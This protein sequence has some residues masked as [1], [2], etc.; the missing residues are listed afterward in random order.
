M[1]KRVLTGLISAALALTLLAGCGSS[2]SGSSSASAPK[3]EAAAEETAAGETAEETAEEPAAEEGTYDIAYV[4]STRDEF[5]G[6]LEE[7]VQE[8][9]DAN[10]VRVEMLYAGNDSL[11]MIDCVEAA[12]NSDKDA[13]IINLNAAEDAQACIEAAGDMKVVFI[14]RVPADYAVLG[15][16]AAAVASDEHQSGKFQGEFLAEYF[17]GTGKTD[18]TYLLLRGTGGLV[19]TELRTEGAINALKEGGIN[20]TEAAVV[21]ADYNREAAKNAMAE[22]LSE[23][24]FDCIISNN[25]AM[26]LGAIAAMEEADM[27]PTAIP[28]VGID[29]TEDG[30]EAIRNGQMKMTVFQS[31]DG[32]A[33]GAVKAAIKMLEGKDRAEGTECERAEDSEYVLYYPFVPITADNVDEAN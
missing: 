29:A 27:D 31:A 20:L 26:A 8:A 11:K 6:L 30:K 15:P 22:I 23:V 13:V 17:S 16:N 12:R 19:H 21:D 24:T 28:I 1:R 9:A 5:L 25:D 7:K 18:V 2:S 3:E 4:L 33:N 14:N 10:G 32:Q